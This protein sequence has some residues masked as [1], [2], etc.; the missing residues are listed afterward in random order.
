MVLQ[1]VEG[2]HLVVKIILMIAAFRTFGPDGSRVPQR[3]RMP[4][5]FPCFDCDGKDLLPLG[6]CPRW[7]FPWLFGRGER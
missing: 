1:R 2:P 5:T 3:G 6:F 4:F 7:L